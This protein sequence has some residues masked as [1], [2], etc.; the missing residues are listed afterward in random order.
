MYSPADSNW[1]AYFRADRFVRMSKE[2][3]KDWESDLLADADGER[4]TW[5]YLD[6]GEVLVAEDS[7]KTME[8]RLSS[9]N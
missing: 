4:L 2:P 9:D 7:M 8:A 3:P 1:T 6:N 5:I